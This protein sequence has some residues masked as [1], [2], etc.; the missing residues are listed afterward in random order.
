M[1]ESSIIS[2]KQSSPVPEEEDHH[3]HQQ[4]SHRTNTKKRVRSDPGYRGVRMR[5]WGKWVSEIREPRKKSRIWLGTFSTPEMAARAHDAAALTIK[6]TSA[7]LNFPELATYLPRPASSSPRDVQAAAAVAAAMDFSPSSS[8]LVVS[9]P[10]TVI[11]PAETQLSSS[12]YSTCTSSSLSPS[13]EEAASTA[14]ELSE[15]VEL[16]SLETSYDESLSEFVY[17]DSAYPPSSPWYINNCYSFYYHSDE[18]G[19]SMAEPFDSSN[20]GPLFP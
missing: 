11:A 3:H 5:T 1:T 7:V 12:S 16:P 17:V 13:S 18:N 10:T 9:D 8:S 2:V 6:G 15:I 14:E 20:F 19:I 4:D